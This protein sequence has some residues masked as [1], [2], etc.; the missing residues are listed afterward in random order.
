MKLKSL[1]LTLFA[2]FATQMM[3][4]T[5]KDADFSANGIF[6]V[7]NDADASTVSVSYEKYDFANHTP[8]T[9][10]TGAITI[11]ATVSN[12]G[13]TFPVTGIY[14][15]AFL[16]CDGLTSITLPEGITVIGEEAFKGC[17][18]LTAIT[19]PSTVTSIEKSAFAQCNGITSITIPDATKEFGT[20]IFQDCTSL[21][22]VTLPTGIETIANS[23]FSGCTG[24]TE[25]EIPSTVTV[26]DGGAFNGCS[27][28]TKITIGKNVITIGTNALG[29][30]TAMEDINVDEENE[31]YSSY[32]G[33]LYTKDFTTLK[34]IPLGKKTVNIK[35]GCTTFG[36]SCG[37]N[38]AVEVLNLAST[39]ATFQGSS[40]KPCENLKEVNY[41]YAGTKQPTLQGYSSPFTTDLDPKPVLNIP[42]GTIT[43]FSNNKWKNAF[44]IKETIPNDINITTVTG[45]EVKE[46]YTI[47]GVRA[48]QNAK[49]AVIIRMTDG[50]T[51]KTMQK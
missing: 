29:G 22:S 7:I 1:L 21:T 38:A 11:P 41:P 45:A 27:G 9:N 30:C 44:D 50:K 19:L 2:A 14:T 15:D 42:E 43:Y 10:Y 51:V 32:D 40:L 5:I 37:A 6:Y 16:G 46:I 31:N 47:G 26:L 20:N 36:T 13:K 35:E 3:A 25:F 4:A 18:A 34:Q 28:L 49:G 33:C 24:L 12:G 8:V 23:M 39:V 17:S 48:N